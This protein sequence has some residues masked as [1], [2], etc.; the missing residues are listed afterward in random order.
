MTLRRGEHPLSR[1]YRNVTSRIFS[2]DLNFLQQHEY[3]IIERDEVHANVEIV[4]Q[5]TTPFELVG[6]SKESAP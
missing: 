6:R 1:L 4:R 3:V 5:F 2:R